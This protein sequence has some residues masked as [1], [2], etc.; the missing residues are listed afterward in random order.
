MSLIDVVP[1]GLRGAD[2]AV[3]DGDPTDDDGA[4]QELL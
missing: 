4:R 3:P 2:H 1:E